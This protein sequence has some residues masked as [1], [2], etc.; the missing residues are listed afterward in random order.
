M[1][2]DGEKK[3]LKIENEC[4]IRIHTHTNIHTHSLRTKGEQ[5]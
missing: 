5:N 4:G 1:L 2:A 3:G